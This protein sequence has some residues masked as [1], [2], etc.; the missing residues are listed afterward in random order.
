MAQQQDEQG[1]QRNQQELRERL[2]LD[3][4]HPYER[5]YNQQRGE[6]RPLQ[7]GFVSST[8][9]NQRDSHYYAAQST[10]STN[11]PEQDSKVTCGKDEITRS[12]LRQMF[13]R[14]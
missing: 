8:K 6:T 1:R 3:F 2:R 9:W 14:N 10:P 12:F 13:R 4:S 5:D 11:G 7:S